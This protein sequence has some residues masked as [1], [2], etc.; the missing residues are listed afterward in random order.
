MPVETD[1]KT[2]SNVTITYEPLMAVQAPVCPKCG[3]YA[4]WARLPEED[5]RVAVPVVCESCSWHGV[6]PRAIPIV[7]QA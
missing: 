1:R 2:F 3:H 4:L 6:A 5:L 7:G